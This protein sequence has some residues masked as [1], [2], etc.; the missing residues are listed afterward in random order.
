M[1]TKFAAALLA[2]SLVAG[3]ALAA[4][5][6]G[7][8]GSLPATQT[9]QSANPAKTN[10]G[11]TATTHKAVKM[12]KHRSAHVRKHLASGKTHVVR[13]ARHNTPA[14]THQAGVIKNNKRS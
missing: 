1:L 3:S 13:H 6:S 2:T 11:K 14:K 9:S 7:T 8:S 10:A 12:A 4:Q 5:P